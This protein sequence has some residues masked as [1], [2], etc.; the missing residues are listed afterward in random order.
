VPLPGEGALPPLPPPPRPTDDDG[1]LERLLGMVRKTRRGLR[2]DAFTAVL[3][4][5]RLVNTR[6]RHR[7]PR[8]SR[9]RA[10]S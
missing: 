2:G 8:R 3:D 6:G 9:A 7:R 1:P 10:A 5:P 4:R